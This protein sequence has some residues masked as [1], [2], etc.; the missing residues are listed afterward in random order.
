MCATVKSNAYGQWAAPIVR[1]GDN[2]KYGA[3]RNQRDKPLRAFPA[4]CH[5]SLGAVRLLVM[6]RLE[7]HPPAS[8]QDTLRAAVGVG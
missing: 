7:R 3:N 1:S 8:P 4:F 6:L 5:S 2:S